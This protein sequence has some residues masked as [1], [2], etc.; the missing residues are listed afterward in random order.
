MIICIECTHT[1]DDSTSKCAQCG[2]SLPENMPNATIKVGPLPE[3]SDASHHGT[4]QT[5]EYSGQEV[6]LFIPTT[7]NLPSYISLQSGQRITLGRSDPTSDQ[8]PDVDLSLYDAFEKGVS[9]IHAM[10][11]CGEDAVVLVDLLSTNGTH[12]NERPIASDQSYILHDRDNIRLG[13]FVAHILFQEQPTV[14]SL[15]NQPT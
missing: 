12:L 6:M 5:P 1:N 7:T 8:Q 11:E 14:E 13:K 15:E 9:R 2:H 10:I 4:R 3:L